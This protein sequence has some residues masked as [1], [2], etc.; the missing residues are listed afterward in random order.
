MNIAIEPTVMVFRFEDSGDDLIGVLVGMKP[1]ENGTTSYVIEN[2]YFPIIDRSTGELG[3]MP[4][5]VFSTETL[6]TFPVSK[7]QFYAPATDPIA[8]EYINLLGRRHQASLIDPDEIQEAKK[9]FKKAMKT[10]TLSP[11]TSTVQ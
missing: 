10:L 6:F 1:H 5:C 3:L 9:A 4:Y 11:T 2:P 7:V 8:K